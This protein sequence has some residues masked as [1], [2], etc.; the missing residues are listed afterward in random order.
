MKAKNNPIS[1]LLVITVGFLVVYLITKMQWTIYISLGVGLIGII[2]KRLS[3][4]IDTVW[5]KLAQVLG[6][7]V[8]N[9]IL[10]IVFYFFLFPLSLLSKLFGKSD[11]LNLNNNQESLF[12]V[13]DK[14]Y[15]KESFEKP[16]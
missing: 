10:S 5:M 11:P 16:W 14:N 15:E 7:I 3:Y 13:V 1:T 6:Y 8:P 2:S 4:Y 9:I 12:V